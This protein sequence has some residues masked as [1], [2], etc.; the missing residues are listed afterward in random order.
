[1][2]IN[3]NYACINTLRVLETDRPDHIMLC[4]K[5]MNLKYARLI[6]RYVWIRYKENGWEYISVYDRYSGIRDRH[7]VCLN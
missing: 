3:H 1:M 5:S 2:Y 7:C 4:S 6:I